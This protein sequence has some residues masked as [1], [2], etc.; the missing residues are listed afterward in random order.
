MT[1]GTST[2]SLEIFNG[3]YHTVQRRIFTSYDLGSWNRTVFLQGVLMRLK[4]KIV[5][6]DCNGVSFT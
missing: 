2:T 6:V 1:G 4:G 5:L 3:Y